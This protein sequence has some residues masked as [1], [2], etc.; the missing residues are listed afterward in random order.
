MRQ[1]V[2]RAVLE[3]ARS[4]ATAAHGR[5][6]LEDI[7]QTI[8]SQQV[9]LQPAEFGA[10]LLQAELVEW[11]CP[12]SVVSFVCDYARE[13]GVVDRLL[14]VWA[15]GRLVLDL[16]QTVSAKEAV[17]LCP[18]AELMTLARQIA[19]SDQIDW[20]V[21]DPLRSLVDS[22]GLFH[23]IVGCLPVVLGPREEIDVT[24]SGRPVRV[25]DWKPNLLIAS[26]CSRLADEGVGIFV[27]GPRFAFPDRRDSFFSLLRE[28]GFRV[29]AYV[30]TPPG[31]WQKTSLPF[32]LAFIRRG[33][34]DSLF[35]GEL[36]DVAARNMV[37]L[38]NLIDHRPGSDVGLGRVVSYSTFQSYQHLVGQERVAEVEDRLGIP[39]IPLI[40][41]ATAINFSKAKESP[42]FEEEENAIYVPLIGRSDVRTLLSDLTLKPHN[43]AQVVL[44]QTQ[45]DA[46]YVAGFLNS[47]DGL[48]VRESVLSGAF[49]PKITKTSIQHMPVFL[50]DIATSRTVLEVDTQLREL[51][52]EL[53]ELR[54]TL[55]SNPSD[56]ESA[57]ERLSRVNRGNSLVD[58]LESLPFPLATILWAY[59]TSRVDDLRAYKRLLHFFE[60]LA[61]LLADIVL[62]AFR[63]DPQ[64]FSSEWEKL[65]GSL[66]ETGSS[67]EVGTFGLWVR[68]FE[69][70]AKVARGLLS[71]KPQEASSRCSQLF[72]SRD[73]ETVS[74]LLSTGIVGVL[75]KANAIRNKD[76]HGGGL[77]QAEARRRHD[78]LRD[79][80]ESVRSESAGAWSRFLMLLPTSMQ[81]ENGIYVTSSKAIVGT[82]TPF[83]SVSVRL[84]HPMTTNRLHLMVHGEVMAL[85]LRP[86]LRIMP[87]P[88]SEENACYFYN[89]RE[90][91]KV[92]F[93]SYHFDADADVLIDAPDTL[94]F[95]DEL[96]E[97]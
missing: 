29:E 7:A 2:I 74:T 95:L 14:D 91:G 81:F 88:Q 61:E 76:A 32:G 58:W 27:V 18:S 55:W 70:L 93:V 48:V 73:V 52:S 75:Q 92:R 8:D 10:I 31:T 89:R 59:W 38:H 80:L 16:R 49:I 78:A 39:G 22:D 69:R 65:R 90:D 46:R 26:A 21:G 86:L 97:R 28:V 4:R 63:N 3:E 53:V 24:F 50:P 79:L 12:H 30:S 66:A 33:E 71:G 47:P 5:P 23:L 37:L 62:S 94:A 82:R 83:D 34:S 36:S 56:I 35:V 44:D 17:A 57:V 40:K 68:I 42:G 13:L 6:S 64:L 54:K 72:R 96:M 25:A 19:G 85:E 9:E 45:A 51:Q 11:E 1:D 67:L 41:I 77:G 20:R 84:S 87:S 43:Y 60:A 15:S